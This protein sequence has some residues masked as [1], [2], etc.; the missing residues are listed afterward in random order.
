MTQ[1][2]ERLGQNPQARVF[3]M[4][5]SAW[6]VT[7]TLE[8]MKLVEIPI[9]MHVGKILM[10]ITASDTTPD[11]VKADA[12][13]RKREK[14][15]ANF[16]KGAARV[17]V[18]LLA[19]R[20]SGNRF[21][22]GGNFLE[23]S[24]LNAAVILPHPVEWVKNPNALWYTGY[25]PG[26][27]VYYDGNHEGDDTILS[28]DTHLSVDSMLKTWDS[29]GFNMEITERK[30]GDNMV[31]VGMTACR[32]P[33]GTVAAPVPEIGRNIINSAWSLAGVPEP[34]AIAMS[35]AIRARMFVNEPLIAQYF[36]AIAQHWAEKAD[37][38]V[39]S[40]TADEQYRLYGA[41]D[42][43]AK[44][45]LADWLT[46]PRTTVT[47]A[48]HTLIRAIHGKEKSLAPEEEKAVFEKMAR[49]LDCLVHAP[50]APETDMTG[51]F[52]AGLLA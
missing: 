24:V 1:I 43:K 21:T 19:A 50:L 27:K 34:H 12:Q 22:S 2:F 44:L 4:D 49:Q 45:T 42:P 30:I 41:Y 9:V 37:K 39:Y 16:V 32:L 52:P 20:T 13:D 26:T 51:I 47:T 18:A 8:L 17:A 10:E 6:D 38:K 33:D 3:E 36:M 23:N 11:M 35:F 31:F 29:L 40:P 48:R 14:L 28:T 15:R 25:K 5:G 7:I 46:L